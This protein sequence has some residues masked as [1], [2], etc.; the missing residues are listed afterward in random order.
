MLII[1]II[2]AAELGDYDENTHTPAFVSEFRFIPD[3]NEEMEVHILEQYKKLRY[4]LF[5]YLGMD[6]LID[7]QISSFCPNQSE[8]EG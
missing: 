2:I 8:A 3:Q 6:L 7:G 5:L 4:K 1:L